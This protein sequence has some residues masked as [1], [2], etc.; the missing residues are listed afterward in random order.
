MTW[1][2]HIYLAEHIIDTADT[3]PINPLTAGYIN[4]RDLKRVD[5]HF[6]KSE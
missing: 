6:V 4:Q 3:R 1:V 5:L 2:R